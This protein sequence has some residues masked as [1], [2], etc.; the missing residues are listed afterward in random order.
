MILSITISRIFSLRSPIFGKRVAKLLKLIRSRNLYPYF[1]KFFINFAWPLVGAYLPFD[2]AHLLP[3][4]ISRRDFP[5][6]V[7]SIFDYDCLVFRL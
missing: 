2:S 4:V 3:M 1:V 6:A 7:A 5:I